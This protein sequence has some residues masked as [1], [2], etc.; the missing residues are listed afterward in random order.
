MKEFLETYGLYQEYL[1][2]QDYGLGN[3]GFVF[4]SEFLGINFDYYCPIED[5]VRPFELD[6]PE[7]IKK[8]M[9]SN[10]SVGAS[11]YENKR[12]PDEQFID[13]KLNYTFQIFGRCKSCGVHKIHFLLNVYSNNPIS[14]INNNINNIR[15]E[16]RNG[17][18][19]PNTNIY[20]KKV[21]CSPENKIKIDKAIAK[22]FDKETNNWLYKAKKS[23]SLNF[24]I[25]S[26]GYFRR[27]IEKELLGIMGEIQQLPDSNS[28]GIQKLLDQYEK[29]PKTYT[30]YENIFQYLPSS[31]KDLGDNPIKLLYQQTS[32]GLH[33]L[34]EEECLD[35]A[36]H[37]ETLLEYTV[38]KINEEK[39]DIKSVKDAIR[40]LR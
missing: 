22:H 17:Y 27:I 6:F 9:G 3:E 12:I 18:A 32:E 11:E 38:R 7:D 1:L 37:I 36:R 30:I 14:N 24:G 28:S 23:L 2:L 31:L 25:G 8:G 20:I 15:F 29:N 26:F 10:F 39:S 40:K 34:T 21:G 16:P 35:R 19:F 33:A 13:E 5:S 4:E